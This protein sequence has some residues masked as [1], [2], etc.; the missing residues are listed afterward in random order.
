MAPFLVTRILRRIY[1]H[2]FGFPGAIT[3]YSLSY[4]DLGAGLS[5]RRITTYSLSYTDLAPDLSSSFCLSGAI[6]THS[7]SY[8][9]LGAGLFIISS[10]PIRLIAQAPRQLQ[11]RL[12]DGSSLSCPTPGCV[13]GG[14]RIASNHIKGAIFHNIIIIA[15][16]T[17]PVNTNGRLCCGRRRAH[18]EQSN[19][20]G[21]Q[22]III[23]KLPVF[24]ARQHQALSWAA[25]R[26]ARVLCR[27]RGVC[28]FSIS[29]WMSICFVAQL[30]I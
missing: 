22:S 1:L 10:I 24:G 27:V 21:N 18:S 29:R 4:M 16:P 14:E 6:T 17:S 3:T 23:L 28:L 20:K 15:P 7:L 2:L 30:V 11:R 9:D 12:L 5:I 25:T 26:P 19:S 8:T 13:A